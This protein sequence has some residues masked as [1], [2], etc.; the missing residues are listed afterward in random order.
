M[1]THTHTH[2]H[3]GTHTHTHAHRHTHTHTHTHKYIATFANKTTVV[4]CDLFV[5]LLHMCD[6]SLDFL[7]QCAACEAQVER[8]G[9]HDALHMVTDLEQ[10]RFSHFQG[11]TR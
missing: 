7:A 5:S 1:H 3:T 6:A 2:T 11:F 9:Q 4:V 10:Q 8:L